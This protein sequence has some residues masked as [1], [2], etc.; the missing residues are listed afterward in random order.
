MAIEYRVIE[1]GAGKVRHA[2]LREDA[3]Q[4]WI[5]R[6]D[7]SGTCEIRPNEEMLYTHEV[8][9]PDG[10]KTQWGPHGRRS[11]KANGESYDEAEGI[12]GM[13][14]MNYSTG[15]F[16]TPEQYVVALTGARGDKPMPSGAVWFAVNF[17]NSEESGHSSGKANVGAFG[18]E[19]GVFPITRINS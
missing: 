6:E 16:T 12:K 14:R 13:V 5:N 8:T 10:Y 2:F 17:V 18:G 7:T 9:Y 19:Y 1:K 4:R 3:A 11:L 15:E